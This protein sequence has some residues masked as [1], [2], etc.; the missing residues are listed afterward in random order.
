MSKSSF[1]YALA[2]AGCLALLAAAGVAARAQSVENGVLDEL[3]FARAAPAAYAQ[4][5][6]R[7]ARALR[8]EAA[9]DRDPG[10]FDEAVAFLTRQRSLPPLQPDEALR[11]VA[12][13]HA[14]FQG[15]VGSV[16]HAGP[17]DETF[18]QRMHRY[19]VWASFMAED[20]SYGFADPHEVVRQLIVDSG[21]P[22]RGHRENIFNPLVRSAGV[23]CAPHR[24]Y[25]AMCVVDF[26]SAP[27]RP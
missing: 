1:K 13:S 8:Y 4:D 21:V 24:V 20:I 18:D 6:M 7:D 22:D 25:G 16:G 15:R 27:V 26:V 11:S 23:A 12:M 14:A 17:G 2:A 3:N 19:G 10:A 5:L 9:Q